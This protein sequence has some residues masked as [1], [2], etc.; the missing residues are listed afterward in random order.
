MI[1]IPMQI[2]I[3]QTEVIH[4]RAILDTQAMEWFVKVWR[5]SIYDHIFAGFFK[6]VQ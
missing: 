5:Q 3:I 6:N 1:V 2:A 4:A